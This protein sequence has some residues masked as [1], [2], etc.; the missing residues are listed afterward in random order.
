[1]LYDIKNEAN[2]EL[3]LNKDKS[4][5]YEYK[6]NTNILAGLLKKKLLQLYTESNIE[7]RQELYN[8]FIKRIKRYLVP[9]RPDRKNPRIKY[10]GKNKYRTNKRRNT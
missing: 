8:E 6:L 9:I 5:K 4:Y 2:K 3:E 10:N 7:K 1:M